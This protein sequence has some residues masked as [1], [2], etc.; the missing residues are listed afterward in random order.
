MGK[1]ATI[2]VVD[3]ECSFKHINPEYLL[4]IKD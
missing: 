1:L 3:G 2:R 4:A